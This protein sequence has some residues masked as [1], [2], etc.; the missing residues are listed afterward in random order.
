MAESKR[1]RLEL[2]LRSDEAKAWLPVLD[3]TDALIDG[4]QSPLGME[5]L[6]TV[7]WLHERQGVPLTLADMRTALDSW[8]AGPAAAERKQRLFSDRLLTHAI[9][10][11][12]T[13]A[14]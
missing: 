7:D 5:V 6:A 13:I 10:R 9:E 3:A 14:A 11:L 2:Y 8:P 1:E 4:F 12:Q